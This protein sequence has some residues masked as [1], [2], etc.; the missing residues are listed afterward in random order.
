MVGRRESKKQID[1]TMFEQ[2]NLDRMLR[3]SGVRQ[4]LEGTMKS[5][6]EEALGGFDRTIFTRDPIDGDTIKMVHSAANALVVRNDTSLVTLLSIDRL[7]K[8]TIDPVN[9]AIHN[10]HINADAKDEA[11]GTSSL[12]KI[13]GTGGSLSAAASNHNHS[14]VNFKHDYTDEERRRSIA[15]RKAVE[16]LELVGNLGT[17]EPIKELLL[18]LAHQLIDDPGERA[19]D[20]QARKEQDPA[21]RH[22]WLMKHDTEYYAAWMLDNDPEYKEKAGKEKHIQ[23]MAERGRQ[24]HGK[25]E[26]DPQIIAEFNRKHRG[27]L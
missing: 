14:S 12:R 19:D 3:L 6:D 25:V 15:L 1:R 24:R 5:L 22:E 26:D 21:Y 13:A 11:Q 7:G 4:A 16:E 2:G 27:R 9:S 18:D 20:W 10:Y 8:A 17:L 23:D